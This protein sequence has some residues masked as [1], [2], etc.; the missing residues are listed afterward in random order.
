MP[1][2]LS[3]IRPDWPAPPGVSAITTTRAGGVSG[4]PWSSLNLGQHVGDDPAQVAENRLRLCRAAKLS[5]QQFGWIEQV[6]G[7]RV[8]QLPLVNA[9]P[10]D[11]SITRRKGEACVIMTAD[12]LPVLFCDD[13]GSRAGAAHAGWRGLCNGVL[14][15][16]VAAL[17]EADT[18]MAWLGPAIGP[19]HFEVGPEVREAFIAKSPAASQAFTATGARPGHFMADIYQIARLRLADVGVT[20]VYG[21][22]LCTVSD[23][24]R[25]YSFRRDGQTGRMASVIWLH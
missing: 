4:P 2:E 21:G 18:L 20:R 23:P 13:K 24:E 14:E 6:H 17:G 22:Q 19:Q 3:L 12:C 25:F 11:A 7:T 8:V 16:T 9:P 1:T 10:A 5:S 15:Q